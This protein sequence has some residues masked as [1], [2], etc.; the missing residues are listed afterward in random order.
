MI[1]IQIILIS[2]VV[3]IS[4]YMYLRLRSGLL[5][6]ILIFLFCLGAVFFIMMPEKTTE[7][8]QALGVKRGI[9]LVFYCITLFFFFLILKLY[10]RVRRLENK[11]TELVRDNSLKK[12]EKLSGS[13][14]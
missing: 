8:A 14:D 11:F 13:D 7:I 10:A 1:P 2:A 12:V 4:F 5:D 3:F 6:A 9:N